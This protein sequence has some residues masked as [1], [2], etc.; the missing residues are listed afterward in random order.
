[1]SDPK[2]ANHLLPPKDI[3]RSGEAV[4]S[5]GQQFDRHALGEPHAL[6]A[7]G[8]EAEGGYQGHQPSPE[9]DE[10]DYQ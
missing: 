2:L 6:P 4:G 7:L 9:P 10:M 5:A 1:M 3:M 8:R